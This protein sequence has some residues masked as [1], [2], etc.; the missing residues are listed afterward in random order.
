MNQE[1]RSKQ[2][3]AHNLSR[4]SSRDVGRGYS[5]NIAFADGLRKEIDVTVVPNYD[6]AIWIGNLFRTFVW[7]GVL[8]CLVHAVRAVDRFIMY[9]HDFMKWF[10]LVIAFI[11][12]LQIVTT[13]NC[14][15]IGNSHTVEFTTART[16]SSQ[17]AVSSPVVAW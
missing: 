9:S 7:D 3:G 14:C 1:D 5:K 13:S 15:A 6:P 17:S 12:H 11:E 4:L 10:G 2:S 16:K 8:H